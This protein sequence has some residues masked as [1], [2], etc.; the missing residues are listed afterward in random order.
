MLFLTKNVNLKYKK[1]EIKKCFIMFIFVW[2]NLPVISIFEPKSVRLSESY[3]LFF[4]DRSEQ[5]SRT[6]SRL[7]HPT[8]VDV[9]IVQIVVINFHESSQQSGIFV[10]QLWVDVGPRFAAGKFEIL[11]SGVVIGK[12]IITASHNI[13]SPQIPTRKFHRTEKTVTN[14]RS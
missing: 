13:Q 6:G 5:F 10:E 2:E 7:K 3:K 12:A 8:N 11:S 14:V 4:D 9:D 1:K